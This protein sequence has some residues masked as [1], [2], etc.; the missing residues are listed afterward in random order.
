MRRHG[1]P[2]TS[3]TPSGFGPTAGRLR[4][5]TAGRVRAVRG[6]G[7]RTPTKAPTP[8]AGR[9]KWTFDAARDLARGT[10]ADAAPG[11][12]DR[13]AADWCVPAHGDRRRHDLYF[14][15]DRDSELFTSR[16]T[17]T[18][19]SC[20]VR[21]RRRRLHRHRHHH[22]HLRP[23]R[24]P[25]TAHPLGRP[26]LRRVQHHVERQLQRLDGRAEPR[27]PR[28][29]TIYLLPTDARARRA[30]ARRAAE[31]DHGADAEDLPGRV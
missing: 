1:R 13:R 11:A 27:P 19:S 9:I 3:I 4:Q 20:S 18:T 24:R 23:S 6:A 2:G 14:E 22:L 28:G 29:S 10:N 7:A 30:T 15:Y 5:R 31:P 16:W 21:R 26:V 8:A 12:D 25:P 17:T